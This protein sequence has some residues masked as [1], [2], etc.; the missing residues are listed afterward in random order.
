MPT[1]G[2]PGGRP[3]T[4]PRE[5]GGWGS[6]GRALRWVAADSR[7][8]QAAACNWR[9]ELRKRG[10]S[11][12]SSSCQSLYKLP[13]R[14]AAPCSYSAPPY[15]EIDAE[16]H[17]YGPALAGPSLIPL[18]PAPALPA[19]LHRNP[20]RLPGT[21]VHGG[22]TTEVGRCCTCG[23]EPGGVPGRAWRAVWWHR[24]QGSAARRRRGGGGGAV[25]SGRGGGGGG[26]VGRCGQRALRSFAS[27]L[28]THT[29]THRTAPLR[30]LLRIPPQPPAGRPWRP[31]MPSLRRARVCGW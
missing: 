22:G 6:R 18:A 27:P 2:A 7:C 23:G 16:L 15:I 19:C 28:P 13:P 1:W 8:S 25:G 21:G 4:G 29:P 24:R 17:W 31:R 30:P 3:G 12:L 10:V 9:A 20:E 26:G 5:A 14:P 11:R